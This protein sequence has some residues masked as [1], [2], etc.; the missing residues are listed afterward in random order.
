MGPVITI[1]LIVAVFAIVMTFGIGAVTAIGKGFGG[2]RKSDDREAAP[3]L[4]APDRPMS[5]G[6]GERAEE[7][8]SRIAMIDRSTAA[9]GAGAYSS[10]EVF[11]RRT[12]EIADAMASQPLVAGDRL[13][14]A[15]NRAPRPHVRRGEE[16]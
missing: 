1:A 9:A 14:Q 4:P 6:P 13:G 5:A 11:T 16:R 7:I 12:G 15:Y 2:S 10:R 3:R 8:A